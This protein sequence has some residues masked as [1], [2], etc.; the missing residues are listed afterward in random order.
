[1]D[2]DAQRTGGNGTQATGRLVRPM[3]L[4]R[5]LRLV[6]GLL[7]LSLAWEVLQ[8][9]DPATVGNLSWWIIV[10]LGSLLV[11]YV[12]NLGFGLSLKSTPLIASGILLGGALLYSDFATGDWFGEPVFIATRL[13]LLYVFTHLGISYL[14]AALLA[15]P[16][17]EM[18][19]IP[20]LIGTIRH[21]DV[22]EHACPALIDHLDK[23]EHDRRHGHDT[24]HE[25]QHTT[26]S[27]DL[28]QSPASYLLLYGVPFL[29]LQLAGNFGGF[30]VATLVPALAFLFIAAVSLANVYRCRRTH[31]ILLA[32]LFLV[33][34][35]AMGLYGLGR[36]SLGADTWAIIVNGALI[37]GVCFSIKLELLYGRY[38]DAG[39]SGNSEG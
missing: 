1:M 9:N 13:W 19:A 16:G 34:G 15:T 38:R 11:N 21:V 7:C 36:F 12:V 18:R 28:L 30:E 17:C 23:W 8:N 3:L 10:L 32:P 39:K 37:I 33:A 29:A 35:L 2:S 27:K 24:G 31:S 6:L 25:R 26:D 14:L 5:L 22:A 4:G 20:H